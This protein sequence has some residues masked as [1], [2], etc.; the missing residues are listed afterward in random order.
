MTWRP[1]TMYSWAKYRVGP[2]FLTEKE[3]IRRNV[4]WLIERLY[5][6]TAAEGAR[7]EGGYPFDGEPINWG[8]L[9]CVE[10]K[11]YNDGSWEVLIEEAAPECPALCAYIAEWLGK[12]DWQATVRTEW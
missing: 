3:V 5:E 7:F 9:S 6:P 1:E 4:D 2:R 8:D 11:Q 12:W 10:V